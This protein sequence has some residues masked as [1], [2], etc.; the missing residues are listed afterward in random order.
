MLRSF[1]ERY[2]V[3]SGSFPAVMFLDRPQCA[4]CAQHF[5]GHRLKRPPLAVQP[6]L[7]DILQGPCMHNGMLAEFHFDHMESEGF[8]L[9]DKCLD[10]SVSAAYCPGFGEGFLHGFQVVKELLI[11]CVHKVGIAVFGCPQTVGHN[12]KAG[13]VRLAA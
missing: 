5:L 1:A 4:E 2:D 8:D 10:R 9:P 13:S 6:V 3:P 7:A 11:T 12:K